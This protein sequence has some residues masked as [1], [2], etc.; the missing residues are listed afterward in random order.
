[1]HPGERRQKVCDGLGVQGLKRVAEMRLPF[2]Q[3]LKQDDSVHSFFIP[4]RAVTFWYFEAEFRQKLC[5]HARLAGEDS[6]FAQNFAT[7]FPPGFDPHCAWAVAFCVKSDFYLC[8]RAVNRSIGTDGIDGQFRISG[9]KQR[10]HQFRSDL[11]EWGVAHTPRTPNVSRSII[12]MAKRV[13][14]AVL[15]ASV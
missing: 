7:V 2:A 6:Y 4:T 14:A 13:A 3:I 5:I 10:L 8:R 1:M 12:A 15:L 9:R 11:T